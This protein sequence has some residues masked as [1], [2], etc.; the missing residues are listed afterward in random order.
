MTFN[1]V[2]FHGMVSLFTSK[3]KIDPRERRKLKCADIEGRK[4][5]F[6]VKF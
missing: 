5:N 3:R 4:G 2:Q 6:T 1:A